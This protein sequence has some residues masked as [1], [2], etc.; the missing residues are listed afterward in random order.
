MN[1]EVA[2]QKSH[3]RKSR[4]IKMT[5]ENEVK[6]NMQ[7]QG[8]SYPDDVEMASFTQNIMMLESI[9]FR[10]E[11]ELLLDS[12]NTSRLA[13]FLSE[14]WALQKELS[15]QQIR[16]VE[17][18]GT[19]DDRVQRL[20]FLLGGRVTAIVGRAEELMAYYQNKY[21]ES[22]QRS[23]LSVQEIAIPYGNV[24]PPRGPVDIGG[25]SAEDGGME[26]RITKLESLAEKTVDR[27][28]NL[29]R[30]V[31]VIRSNYSTK[32]DLATL[33]ST[34][35]KWFIGTAITMVGLAFA[36]AKFIH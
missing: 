22:I 32:A 1:E 2:N 17:V 29:E 19:S 4:K 12:P 9:I 14:M 28:A 16:A 20:Q 25:Q 24:N 26:A 31:A 30:D 13:I 18:N 36:A 15:T 27:L 35:L 3:K 21:E 11:S 33:E 10:I 7:G 23:H 5:S 34:V 6:R 8:G